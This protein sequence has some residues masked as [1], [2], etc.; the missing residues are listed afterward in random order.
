MVTDSQQPNNPRISVAICTCNGEKF[1]VQQLESI[2]KQSHPVQE[3]VLCDDASTDSTPELVRTFAETSAIPIKLQINPSR[4]GVTKN[5]EQAISQCTGD[6]I[7][8]SDQDDL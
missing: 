2:I 8:L 7:F 1:V 6:F 5:F 3:I 4:L